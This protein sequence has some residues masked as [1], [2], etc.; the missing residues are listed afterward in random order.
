MSDVSGRGVGMDAVRAKG[1]ELGGEV[2][3]TST[4]GDGS[5]IEIR[6]PLTLAI[7]SALLVRSAEGTFAIPLDRIDRTVRPGDHVV[8][9]M[10][11]RP[12]LMLDGLVVPI[13]DGAEAL[14]RQPSSE[15]EFA[16]LL[17]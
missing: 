10:L 5:R 3:L 16:V 11:G 9:S 14:A 8:R 7:L 15:G 4:P 13:V 2:S 1:R 12:N 6:L 17:R